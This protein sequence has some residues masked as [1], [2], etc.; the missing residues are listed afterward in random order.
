M[1]QDLL[2]IG[3]IVRLKNGSANLMITARYL[4][5]KNDDI[6]GYFAYSST[7]YPHGI[8]EEQIFYFSHENINEVIFRGY[9]NH[10][11]MELKKLYDS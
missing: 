3:S 1:S 5:Y 11:E 4:I 2:P 8:V 9:E 10:Q 7:P 6:V